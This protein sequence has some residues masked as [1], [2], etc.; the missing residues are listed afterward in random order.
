MYHAS[1]ANISAKTRG[2]ALMKAYLWSTNIGNAIAGLLMDV[3]DTGK[4]R[5][6]RVAKSRIVLTLVVK[7]VYSTIAH[8]WLRLL[9]SSAFWV[10]KRTA[11]MSTNYLRSSVQP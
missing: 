5:N 1:N 2:S 8:S 7:K 4:V 11:Y 6:Q 10:K 3:K 9:V